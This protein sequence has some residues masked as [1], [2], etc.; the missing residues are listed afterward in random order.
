AYKVE[1]PQI[2]L[3]EKQLKTLAKGKP[4]Y[5]PVVA[6]SENSGSA[7]AVFKVEA[8]TQ[9]V[10]EVIKQFDQYPVWVDGVQKIEY[11]K[12]IKGQVVN[13]KFTVGKWFTPSFEYHITHNYPNLNGTW[14]SWSLD[15]RQKNDLTG[16]RG[17]WRVTADKENPL[18]SLVE[19]SVNLKTEGLM[20]NIVRPLLVKN[21]TRDATAWVSKQAKIAY[22]KSLT[23]TA[24]NA[25]KS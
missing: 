20:L 11:Y 7:L 10:W 18:Q 6:D 1:P 4:V 12:P 9:F 15:A 13:V 3:T 5:P 19:Y 2:K 21:G 25:K 16:C 14:G 17:F 23:K 8:P 24:S 22:E